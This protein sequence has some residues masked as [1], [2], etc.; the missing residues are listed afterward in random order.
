MIDS[1]GSARRPADDL[2]TGHNRWMGDKLAAIL[3][4]PHLTPFP[5]SHSVP[6]HFSFLLL[7]HPSSPSLPLSL[8]YLP[9]PLTPLSL[10]LSYLPSLTPPLS[11]SSFTLLPSSL[12]SPTLTPYSVNGETIVT[13]RSE[14]PEGLKAAGTCWARWLM[15]PHWELPANPIPYIPFPPL[16]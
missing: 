10:S 8:L 3:P 14:G 2:V 9:L 15:R 13:L 4:R 11:L 1:Q 7:S 6:S 16:L 5:H 12:S